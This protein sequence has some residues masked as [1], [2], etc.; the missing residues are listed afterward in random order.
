MKQKNK[1]ITLIALVITIIILLLLSGI[2][3]AMLSQD[4]GIL[5]KANSANEETKKKNYEEILKIIGNG[6]K[7]D[8]IINHWDNKKFLDEFEKEVRKNNEFRNA[9]LERRTNEILI[10]ITKEGYSYRIQENKIEYIGKQGE[11]RLPTL[12]E[13]HIKFSYQPSSKENEYTNDVVMVTIETSSNQ[14][15]LEFSKDNKT[16]MKYETAISMNEN[17]PIYARLLN[18]INQVEC[19]ATRKYYQY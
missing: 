15:T 18:E 3:I 16:W 13:S 5:N 2:T 8:K 1:G 14:Y 10:I 17:G 19:F 9:T 12:D 4:N 11:N 6:L 7:P